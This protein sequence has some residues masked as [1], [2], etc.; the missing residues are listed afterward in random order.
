MADHSYRPP[1]ER[2]EPGE[3]REFMDRYD[4]PPPRQ[5][6]EREEALLT[7]LWALVIVVVVAVLVWFIVT[8]GEPLT[9]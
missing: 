6:R 1:P 3:H 5:T 8:T 4:A 9:W 7:W 2:R